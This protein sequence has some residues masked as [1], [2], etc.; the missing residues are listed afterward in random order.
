MK[1]L[2]IYDSVYGN[3]AQIARAISET[4]AT[5]AQVEILRVTDVR[6]EQLAGLDLLVVGSPTHGFRPTPAT[7]AFLGRIPA[8]ALDGVR[9]AAFDTRVAVAKVNSAILSG[10]VR[11]FG[12]A[13]EKIAAGLQR[14]GG[15]Q[16]LS[17]IGFVVQGRE[18]PLEEGELARAV[19]WA[20]Q[21]LPA[22]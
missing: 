19:D 2:V 1:A 13:A 10:L 18:G 16:V 9:V 11:L 3:T 14:K 20:R 12:Y 21:L 5:G 6:T 15:R 8:H 7:K 17:P 22:H 4:L